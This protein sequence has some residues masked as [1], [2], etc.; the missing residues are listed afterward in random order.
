[1]Q[2]DWMTKEGAEIVS[3]ETMDNVRVQFA[4]KAAIK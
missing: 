3:E 1:M 4:I 2:T